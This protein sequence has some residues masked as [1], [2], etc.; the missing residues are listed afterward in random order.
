M[1]RG[2]LYQ[3]KEMA[4]LVKGGYDELLEILK[5]AQTENARKLPDSSIEARVKDYFDDADDAYADVGGY[6]F[7][8]CSE[9]REEELS[10]LAD[11]IVQS[12]G[13]AYVTNGILL[14]RLSK[15]VKM[16]MLK[17]LYDKFQ[18]LAARVTL[19]Q[20]ATTSLWEL[21]NAISECYGDAALFDGAFYHLD[22]A[23][24]ELPEDTWIVSAS[25]LIMH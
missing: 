24:R 12:G 10:T 5:L 16:E 21:R 13:E 4:E 14:F 6:E 18:A 25:P 3:F 1:T 11:W 22:Q 17:R 20:F 8:W 2:T 7:S 19:E 15:E 23:I 9:G